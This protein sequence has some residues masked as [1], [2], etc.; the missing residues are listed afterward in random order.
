[1]IWKVF[2]YMNTCV[3]Y[4]LKGHLMFA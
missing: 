2:V 3:S 4:D 1:M